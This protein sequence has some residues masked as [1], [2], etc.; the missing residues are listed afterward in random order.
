MHKVTD[1]LA[2]TVEMSPQKESLTQKQETKADT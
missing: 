2:Q 1:E